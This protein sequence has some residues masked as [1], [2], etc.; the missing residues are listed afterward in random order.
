MRW[1][2]EEDAQSGEEG[3]PVFTMLPKL[4]PEV[5]NKIWKSA[6][7]MPRVVDLWYAP[8]GDRKFSQFCIGNM[9]ARP[10]EYRSHRKAPGMLHTCQEA[11]SV[12]TKYYE[13]SFGSKTTAKI[14]RTEVEFTNPPHIYVH[15]ECDIISPMPT[16]ILEDNEIYEYH[17]G[18]LF[19]DLCGK[20]GIRRLALAANRY[21]WAMDLSESS[22]IEEV[23]IYDQPSTLP[24]IAFDFQK[25]ITLELVHSGEEIHSIPEPDEE[26]SDE[27][28][29]WELELLNSQV[30][31]HFRYRETE[32][33]IGRRGPL[34][35]GWAPPVI[36]PMQ[37]IVTKDYEETDGETL[38]S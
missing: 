30:K 21:D 7:F 34:P 16:R 13:L 5:R 15:W 29:E 38:E 22:K 17:C 28:R 24:A 31:A 12:G 19:S 23:I 3:G 33:G 1:N 25:P 20:R 10:F 8:I 18:F 27:K 2:K 36:K 37:M 35:E 9:N 11:R 26:D 32:E 14:G 6:C 4:P